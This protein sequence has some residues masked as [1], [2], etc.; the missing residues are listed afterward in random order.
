[1]IPTNS[2][3]GP[4]VDAGDAGDL[5]SQAESR[6]RRRNSITDCCLQLFN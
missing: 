6:K 3:W 4:V 5:W 2:T 1:M